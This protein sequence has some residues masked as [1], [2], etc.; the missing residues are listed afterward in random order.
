MQQDEPNDRHRKV[1]IEGEDMTTTTTGDG[2][3]ERAQA[4]GS[5]GSFEGDL[6][7]LLASPILGGAKTLGDLRH[8]KDKIVALHDHHARLSAP[9]ADAG[10]GWKLVPVEPTEEMKIEGGKASRA[11]ATNSAEYRASYIYQC[12]LANAPEPGRKP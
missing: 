6:K 12:M 8:L 10:V 1:F 5:D 2:L 9:Q 7:F 4:F 3:S 11:V